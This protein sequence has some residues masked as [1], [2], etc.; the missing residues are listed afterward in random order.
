MTTKAEQMYPITWDLGAACQWCLH[1]DHDTK[2][3][4]CYWCDCPSRSKA[5]TKRLSDELDAWF[6]A[7]GISEEPLGDVL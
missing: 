7:R 4:A 2:E 1:S 6:Q 5:D 3:E